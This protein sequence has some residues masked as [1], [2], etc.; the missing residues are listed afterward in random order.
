MPDKNNPGRPE[1]PKK[2]IASELKIPIAISSTVL[3]K[4]AIPIPVAVA[5]KEPISIPVAVMPK[6]AIPILLDNEYLL[7][8]HRPHNL[9]RDALNLLHGLGLD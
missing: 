1:L 2:S 3:P 5:P 6:M 7:D 4:I 8:T 9:H